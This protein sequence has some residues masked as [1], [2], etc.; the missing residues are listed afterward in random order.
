MSRRLQVCVMACCF[1]RTPAAQLPGAAAMAGLDAW[2]PRCCCAAA[3]APKCSAAAAAAV[4]GLAPDWEEAAEPCLLDC[5]STQLPPSAVCDVFIDDLKESVL[6]RPP[7]HC[8]QP[9]LAASSGAGQLAGGASAGGW[10]L[11]DGTHHPHSSPNAL[12]PCPTQCAS[13]APAAGYCGSSAA[14]GPCPQSAALP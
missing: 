10:R 13:A 3:A 12:C 5:A 2:P 8:S 7:G 4:E 6:V 1:W 14:P 11:E 9:L